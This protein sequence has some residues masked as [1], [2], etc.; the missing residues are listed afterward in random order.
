MN[1]REFLKTGF[2]LGAGLVTAPVFAGDRIFNKNYLG[3]ASGFTQ[4]KLPYAYNALEPY[5]DAATMD[6]HYNWHHAGYT[7]N[8]NKAATEE[9]LFDKSIEDILSSVSRYPASIR[10]NGGGFYNHNLFWEIMS[11]SGGKPPKGAF[12]RRINKAF[13]SFEDFR[14]QFSQKAASVFGS[15]WAWLIVQNGKLLITATPNQDNPLMDVAPEKGHPLL[16]LDVW[17]HAYYL[18]YQ[19]RRTD[20]IGAFWNVVDWQAVEGRLE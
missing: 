9:G 6:V 10:N 18:R 11:P 17:E 12:M 4:V 2:A 14:T 7:A 19:N 3:Q 1:K 13:G 20:Y 15:G 8:L 16:A 5:I